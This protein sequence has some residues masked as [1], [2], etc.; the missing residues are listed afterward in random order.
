MRVEDTYD[1]EAHQKAKPGYQNPL[2]M[3]QIDRTTAYA[4]AV[5]NGDIIAGQLIILA[6]E[7][8]MRDLE[9]SKH[10]N[11]WFDVD[12]AERNIDWFPE[13]LVFT[14]GRWSGQPFIL[15]PW[16]QFIIGNTFGWKRIF[17]SCPT[18]GDWLALN[19]GNMIH[20]MGCNPVDHV[21]VDPLET[22]WLRRFRTTYKEI[23]RKN[24]K[25]ELEAGIAIRMTGFDGEFGAECYVAATKS[26]QSR[27]PFIAAKKMVEMSE[28]LQ[29]VLDVQMYSITDPKYGSVLKALAASASTQDGL[30]GSYILLE[31]YHAHKTRDLRDVLETSTGARLQPLIDII[32]TAGN[33]SAAVCRIEHDY[34]VDVLNQV[35]PD[36][37][38]FVFI[39][40]M[41]KEDNWED[42]KNWIKANPNLGISVGSQQLID[43]Y[44]KVKNTPTKQDAFKQK[45][46]NMWVQS[47]E[48]WLDIDKLKKLAKKI[49]DDKLKGKAL[50]FGYD[51]A[52]KVDFVSQV[53]LFP[54]DPETGRKHPYLK[55]YFWLP[56]GALKRRQNKRV[57]DQIREWAHEGY[58][59]I[60]PGE[61]V[62]L[63]YVERVAVENAAKYG[64]GIMLYDPFKAQQM[65]VRA[66]K[67]GIETIEF[68]Q[69]PSVFNEPCEEFERMIL[70][71][72]IE[73]D[74]NPVFI[75]MLGNM[76]KKTDENGN[77]KPDRKRSGDKIDGGVAAIMSLGEYILPKTE[78][79]KTIPKG[80]R[81]PMNR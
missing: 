56:E 41:D 31:E 55:S 45:R 64:A 81:S 24:G 2:E 71:G 18:C 80:Y 20:C 57:R 13:Y 38:Y 58:I 17:G 7:R 63:D 68:R 9:E 59:D 32:T 10:K 77:I 66:Q 44:D 15:Q 3:D 42:P 79:G 78:V 76:V 4:E 1:I 26:D 48:R 46:L 6:C 22:Q 37:S 12:C 65:A 50:C 73:H 25:T 72:E 16:Q 40:A 39:A 35:V 67:K 51:A 47:V 33:N 28:K 23:A 36:D 53:I 30:N 19:G 8:H 11:M 29:A 61:V 74:G 70:S 54:P 69:Q 5:I 21:D 34:A 52:E 62:D 49:P 43:L 60:I 27:I 75:W 14:K